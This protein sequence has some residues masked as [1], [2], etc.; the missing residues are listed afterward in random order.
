[1]WMKKC[2]ITKD[3]EKREVKKTVRCY[4]CE[5]LFV[6][7]VALEHHRD[8]DCTGW[9][10]CKI[11]NWCIRGP[12]AADRYKSHARWCLEK[13]QK[14]EKE[15]VA[16]SKRATASKRAIVAARKRATASKRAILAAC[17]RAAASKRAIVAACKRVVASKRAI[18]A[19][20]KRAAAAAA[21]SKR[22]EKRGEERA[23]VAQSSQHW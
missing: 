15:R 18:V 9:Y 7:E 6:S 5:E 22:E 21:A 1:M 11:C 4:R 3:R 16:A 14:K 20:H 10:Q 17:K 8:T 19:A 2:R 13:T 23:G 12:G